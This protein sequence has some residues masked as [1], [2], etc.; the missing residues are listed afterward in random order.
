[1]EGQES[2]FEVLSGDEFRR[3][4]IPKQSRAVVTEPRTRTV[5]FALPTHQG[6]CTCP[7]HDEV[8]KLLNPEQKEYRQKYPTRHV[9]EIREGLL[10]CRDCFIA[11]ADKDDRND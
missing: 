9:F 8:Q 5:W 11:E 6:F 2:L 7:D 3:Q 10:I 4:N 1:M